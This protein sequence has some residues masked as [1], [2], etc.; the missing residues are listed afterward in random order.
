MIV[1]VVRDDADEEASFL[2]YCERSSGQ[3]LF[4]VFGDA[5]A[6]FGVGVDGYPDK[7][8]LMCQLGSGKPGGSPRA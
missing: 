5:G 1:G 8:I 4:D 2:F 6:E 7:E 3:Y